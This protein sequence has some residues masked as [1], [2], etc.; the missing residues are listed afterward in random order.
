MYSPIL[1]FSGRYR[2]NDFEYG[3]M[4]ILILYMNY[5]FLRCPFL[6]HAVK[7]PMLQINA[8][9]STMTQYTEVCVNIWPF[10]CKKCPY[11]CTIAS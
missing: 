7:I 3:Y 6:F 10:Q 1:A 11:V 8:T 9:E 4:G 2:S 5:Y